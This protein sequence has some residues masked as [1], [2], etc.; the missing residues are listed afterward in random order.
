MRKVMALAAAALVLAAC[1]DGGGDDDPTPTTPAPTTSE[2]SEEPSPEPSEDVPEASELL[3]APGSIGDARVGMTIDEALATGLFVDEGPERCEDAPD[4]GLDWKP[5]LNDTF[6]VYVAD[7]RIASMGVSAAG[8][9]NA[10]DLGIGN[11]LLDFRGVYETAEMREAGY[12]QTGLF[13]SDGDNWLGILFDAP[14]DTIEE[15][16]EVTFM[17]VTGSDSRPSL[18]RDGC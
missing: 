8:P 1:G 4:Q 7:G 14:L 9:T 12:G 11:T 17:E 2:P 16:T 13:L 10:E 6:D 18:Q 3:I 15:T 5:P